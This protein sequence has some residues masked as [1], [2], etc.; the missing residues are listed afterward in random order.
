[1]MGA[2]PELTLFR[3]ALRTMFRANVSGS[4]RR[5]HRGLCHNWR[6]KNAPKNNAD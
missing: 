1:V 4:G 5:G 6:M 2:A 3:V